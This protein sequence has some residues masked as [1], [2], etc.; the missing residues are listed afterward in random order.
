MAPPPVPVRPLPREQQPDVKEEL[1]PAL[2]ESLLSKGVDE[3]WFQEEKQLGQ[4]HHPLER[5]V[6]LLLQLQE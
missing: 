3:R 2:K 4:P 5:E 1:V 6:P